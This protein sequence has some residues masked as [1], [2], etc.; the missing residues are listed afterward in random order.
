MGKE[1]KNELILDID[2]H[3]NWVILKLF[4]KKQQFRK[5]TKNMY[6]KI[7]EKY[8]IINAHNYK[9]ENKILKINPRLYN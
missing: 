3:F 7:I 2:R 5:F 4:R 9:L 6:L 8:K 1:I